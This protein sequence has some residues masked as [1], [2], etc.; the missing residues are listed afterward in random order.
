MTS[1]LPAEPVLPSFLISP[2]EMK[3]GNEFTEGKN[4][5]SER[6]DKEFYFFKPND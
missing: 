6:N 3:R 2:S 4:E 5:N 1:K